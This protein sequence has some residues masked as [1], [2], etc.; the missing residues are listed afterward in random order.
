[1]H[2]DA[3]GNGSVEDVQSLLDQ[4]ADIN[5]QNAYHDTALLV[6]LDNAKLEVVE[7]LIKYG[8]DVNCR[9]ETGWS[10][11]SVDAC[12]PISISLHCGV[13]A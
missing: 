7:V 11:D 3:C 5:G 6:A 2:H 1:M 4:G 8:A 10:L 9:D 13:V 12:I